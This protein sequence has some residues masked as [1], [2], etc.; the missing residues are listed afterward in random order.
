MAG[1]QDDIP[2]AVIDPGLDTVLRLCGITAAATRLRIAQNEGFN[3]FDDLGE[4]ENDT[5]VVDMAKRMSSRTVNEGRVNLGTVQVK[6]MQALAWWV[7]DHQKRGQ[8]LDAVDFNAQTLED[9]KVAKRVEKERSDGDVSVKDLST[10][11]PDDFDAHEEAFVNLLAQ[12]QGALK[13]SLRY[14]VREEDEPVEFANDTQK[15]DVSNAIG[16]PWV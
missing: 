16:W 9:A 14:V 13:E 15:T 12:T 6:K 8:P 3:T 10:F 2:Q 11:D 5:D 4:L 1:Q 7:R